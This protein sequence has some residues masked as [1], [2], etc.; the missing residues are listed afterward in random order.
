[1]NWVTSRA[2]FIAG[3]NPRPGAKKISHLLAPLAPMSKRA[4]YFDSKRKYMRH[5]GGRYRCQS[6]Q[7]FWRRGYQPTDPR[8]GAASEATRLL[9]SVSLSIE[10]G[11]TQFASQRSR[12]FSV[13]A[14]MAHPGTL[15]K[16]VDQLDQHYKCS[17]CNPGKCP[18]TRR[19][20]FASRTGSRDIAHDRY[21][22]ISV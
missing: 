6:L 3:R 1:V 15:A 19:T 2:F 14:L 7:L 18:D 4:Y 21:L 10:R 13:G 16:T 22:C 9:S 8:V 5:L 20:V 11:E 12:L 17:G